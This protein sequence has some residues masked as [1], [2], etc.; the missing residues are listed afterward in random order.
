MRFYNTLNRR[1]EE[2]RPIEPGK[3][4]PATV[5]LIGWFHPDGETY[6]PSLF[7]FRGGELLAGVTQRGRQFDWVVFELATGIAGAFPLDTKGLKNV[8]LYGSTG[9]DDA[10][11]FYV[12]GW[13]TRDGGEK[14]LILQIEPTP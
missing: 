6:A 8:L 3:V 13:E 1:L 2:F 14:P 5:T 12:G 11:R 4:G 10:G 7:S 9:R